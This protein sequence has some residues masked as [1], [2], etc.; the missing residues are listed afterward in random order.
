MNIISIKQDL[1]K[2]ILQTE[3]IDIIN[4]IKAIFDSEPENWYNDLPSSIQ[5]S[6]EKG[7][8]QSQ[9]GEGRP[10]DEVMKKYY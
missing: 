1:A 3:N 2:K 8:K 7:L 10:H 6:L 9:S 5:E 4:Y